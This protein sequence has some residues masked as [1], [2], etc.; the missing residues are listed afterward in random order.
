MDLF[1]HTQLDRIGVVLRRNKQTIAVAE[2]VT[3]GMLQ[4]AFSSI[5][6]ASEFYQGGITAYNVAQKYK[7]LLVEPIHALTVNCVSAKVATEMAVQVCELFRSDWGLGITGYAS[8]VP[9]SENKLFAYY[10]I[11]HLGRQKAAGYIEPVTNEPGRIQVN[12]V[13]EVLREFSA[14]ITA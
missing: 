14:V 2:S 7:H 6:N 3:S 8:P 10:S 9:A 13:N 11:V 12:Y 4:F 1:T 5:E